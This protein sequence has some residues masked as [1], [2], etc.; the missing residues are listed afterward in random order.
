MIFRVFF[1]PPVTHCDHVYCLNNR[2]QSEDKD[3]AAGASPAICF[4]SDDDFKPMNSFSAL[5]ATAGID[6]VNK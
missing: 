5:T 1:F 3:H 6:D 2:Y 4:S